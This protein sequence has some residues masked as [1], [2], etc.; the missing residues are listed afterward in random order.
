MQARP[1]LSGE[2]TQPGQSVVDDRQTMNSPLLL[3]QSQT[4]R[5]PVSVAGQS[6]ASATAPVQSLLD[7]LSANARLSGFGMD[8]QST[9]ALT[10][11]GD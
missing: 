6:K 3:D 1:L 2:V 9:A 8:I 10:E 4:Q 5:R 11:T 7:Q